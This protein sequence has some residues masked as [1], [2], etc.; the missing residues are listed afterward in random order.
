MVQFLNLE[1]MK[2][3]H[4]ISFIDKFTQKKGTICYLRPL[5]MHYNDK[6]F[7]E[8]DCKLQDWLRSMEFQDVTLVHH[9]NVLCAG[10]IET[11]QK[12]YCSSSIKS[13]LCLICHGD[14][15]DDE[16]M[17]M[18]RFKAKK[19]ELNVYWTTMQRDCVADRDEMVKFD[20]N[21]EA[22]FFEVI[23]SIKGL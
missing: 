6:E 10:R 19:L 9:K 12:C 4:V 3:A 13:Q 23:E 20:K 1:D 21:R 2:V 7:D 17:N 22:Y 16:I 18:G 14:Y 11:L 5:T 8:F 15:T